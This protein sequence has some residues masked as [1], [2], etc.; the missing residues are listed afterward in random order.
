MSIDVAIIDYG[1]GNLFSVRRAFEYCGAKVL[2]SDDPRA[3]LDA[4]RIVLPGVGA[5]ADGMRGLMERGLNHVAA[6]FAVSGKPFLGICL[7]MQMLASASEEFGEHKG[8]G[9]V[10]GRVAPI[11]ATTIDGRSHKIPHIGWAALTRPPRLSGWAGSILDGIQP[12]EAVYLVHSFAVRPDDDAHRLAD[13][14]YDGRVITA[15]IRKDNVYGTQ[16]HPEKSAAVG[17]RLLRQFLKL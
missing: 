10:P 3:L 15:A 16:F 9:I 17:L 14:H 2:V 6:E 8:L 13:Y 5:F 11:P 12:G 7:G 1:V 4:P